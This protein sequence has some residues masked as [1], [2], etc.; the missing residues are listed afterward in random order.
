M[1]SAHNKIFGAKFS[2][3]EHLETTRLY[4]VSYAI[5]RTKRYKIRLAKEPLLYAI[6]PLLHSNS[7]TIIMQ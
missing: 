2:S 1:S 6:A 3:F 4:T 7:A 5:F